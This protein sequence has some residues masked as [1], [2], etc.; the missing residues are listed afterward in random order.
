MVFRAE[1]EWKPKNWQWPKK[2]WEMKYWRLKQLLSKTHISHH[3]INMNCQVFDEHIGEVSRRKIWTVD[4]RVNKQ[5]VVDVLWFCLP[6]CEQSTCLIIFK[7]SK[8]WIQL[9]LGDLDTYP[10]QHVTSFRSLGHDWFPNPTHVFNISLINYFKYNVQCI[11]WD[12]N[13]N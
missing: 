10:D 4:I 13:Y 9:M 11:P 8:S 1:R 7:W 12:S 2:T 3:F 6:Y 5:V